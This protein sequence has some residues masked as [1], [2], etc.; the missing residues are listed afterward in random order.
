MKAKRSIKTILTLF[1]VLSV[2]VISVIISALSIFS[3]RHSST[4]AVGKYEDAMNEGYQTEIKSQVETAIAVLQAEYDKVQA[5]I[6]TEKEAKEEAKEII[7]IMRYR[8]DGSGYFWID[9]TDYNLVMHPILTEQEGTNRYDLEDQNGVMIIQKIMSAVE[10]AEAGGFNEFYFTKSDGVTVAPK[11]AYSEIFTPWGWVVSTGN[12]V[13]EM[14]Q[15]TQQTKTEMEQMFSR[16]IKEVLLV[17]IIVLAVMIFVGRGFGN[18]LC[19]PIIRLS[20]V[21]KEVS[22]GKIDTELARSDGATEIAALQNSFCD[23]ID[24]FK[25]QADT[26]NQVAGGNLCLDVA[27][28]SEEDMVGN[29]LVKMIADN[30]QMFLKVKNIA[31]QIHSGSEQIA[32]ASQNLAQGAAQQAGAIEKISA[33]VSDISDKSQVNADYVDEVDQIISDTGK[34]AAAGNEKMEELVVA[35]QE[36]T[37][38]SANISKVIKVVRDIAFNTNILAL[39]AA[40]EASRAGEQG[41]GF[42][43]VA[44]EVRSLAAHSAESSSQIED[45]ISDSIQKVE[46][47]FVL[48]QDTQKALKLISDSIDRIMELSKDV[49]VLSKEQAA[50]AAQIN[51]AL[52]EVTAVTSTNSAASEE[53]AASSQ[54]LSNLAGELKRQLSRFRLKNTG[55]RLEENFGGY[56]D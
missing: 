45:L 27:A 48:A 28:K 44:E 54:E 11:I 15:E 8:D 38:A 42:A 55:S 1:F 26:I 30:N 31:G 47:G 51:N 20:G 52:N 16:L 4:Q 43:V 13:D 21:A 32:A 9:D 34:N 24:N 17:D 37:D 6:L 19:N 29:A 5:G 56:E 25:Y 35:M 23:M 22:V 41:K 3:L 7:R 12:Y 39:N 33:S 36:I 46:K 50:T 18:W 14:Q 40:V 53:F 10:G 2:I 49:S